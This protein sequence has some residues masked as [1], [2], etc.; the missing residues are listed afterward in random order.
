VLAQFDSLFKAKKTPHA[1]CLSND[2][3]EPAVGIHVIIAENVLVLVV[4]VDSVQVDV[5]L[6]H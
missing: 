5:F 3:V 1:H 2:F 6:R 4:A